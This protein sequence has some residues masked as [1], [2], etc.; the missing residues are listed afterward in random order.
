MA[1]KVKK[2]RFKGT[3]SR[4]AAKQARGTQLGHLSLPKGLPV[5]KE[6]PGSRVSLDIIP[7]VVTD[8]QHPDKDEEYEIAVE[9]S[10]WY[11]R[12]YWLHRNIGPENQAVVCP[13]SAAQKC[14]ICEYRAQLLKDGADWQDESVK[15]LKASMRN[16][17]FAVPKGAKKYEETPHVWDISQFLFQTKLNEEIGENEDYE[18]FPDLEDGY[19]L[20]IRFSEESL[21]ANKYAETS[22]IDFKERDKPYKESIIDDLP[23]LDALLDVPSYKAVEAMFFGGLDQEEAEEEVEVTDEDAVEAEEEEEQP[24]PARKRKP[25][26]EPEDD[27]E[28]EEEEEDE[29]EEE[30]EEDEEEEEVKPKEKKKEPP[31]KEPK[32]KG[33]GK[34]EKCPH[35]HTF[36]EDCE[37]YDECDE[38]ELWEKC[39]DASEK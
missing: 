17:Y 18:T 9:G 31:K 11:K 15:A 24:K 26:P 7:Y 8:S 32:G 1:K 19:T 2:K 30:E 39:M 4:N 12:P 35:G 20:Q 21:G 33:K 38:C 3:V 34:T 10:L 37:E 14:P 29:E 6:E 22:R 36:G 23:S 16:L 28:E 5:F 13:V 27:D 25:E